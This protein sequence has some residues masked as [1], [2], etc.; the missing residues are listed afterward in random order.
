[1][2]AT[3]RPASRPKVRAN[4]L[5]TP[6]VVALGGGTGLPVVLR[7]IRSAYRHLD[8]DRQS[9]DWLTAMVTVMDD[10]GSSGSLRKSL[11]VLPPGDIRNCLAALVRRPTSLSGII[12]DRLSGDAG[13]TGHPIGNLLLAALSGTEGDLLGAIAKLGAQMDI[14][15]RVLPATLENAHLTASFEDGSDVLGEAAITARGGRIK[16]LSLDR[17]VRP[18]PN[19]IEALINA[20]LIVVGPGSLYTSLLPNLLVSGVAATMSAVVAPRVYVA[21]LMTQPGETDGYTVEDHLRAIGDHTGLELFDYVLVNRTK[22]PNE[23]VAH[24]A[25]DGAAVVSAETTAIGRASVISA[26]LATITAGGQ[27][28][29]DPEALG[30]ALARIVDAHSGRHSL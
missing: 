4:V 29:H 6:R 28:R 13:E 9:H 3:A 22:L 5:R 27:I 25:E 20:D 30:S 1:M 18:V 24:Y 21:N 11:G 19:V 14:S 15:G 23:A 12:H 10:G 8:C 16:K 26:H 7:G 2:P 17:P